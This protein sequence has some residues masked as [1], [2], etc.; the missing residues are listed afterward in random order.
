MQKYAPQVS[1]WAISACATRVQNVI[2]PIIQPNC[3]CRGAVIMV[4]VWTLRLNR[5][6]ED[7]SCLESTMLVV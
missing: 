2:N 3:L 1:Y 7:I 4:G 5:C 6:H